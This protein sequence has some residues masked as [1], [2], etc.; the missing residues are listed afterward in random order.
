[1]P[2]GFHIDRRPPILEIT[3]DRG[4]ANVLDAATSRELGEVFLGFRDD[5]ANRVAIVTG[6]GERFFCAGWDLNAAAG[7]E[8][9]DDDFGT[10]GFGGFQSLADLNKP[11]ICAVNGMAVG[12]GFEMLLAA[13]L[14]V[15][16]E[17]A[18]FFMPEPLVGV[19]PDTGT[20]RLSRMIPDL[21]AREMLLTGKRLNA[22]EAA[23]WGLVN[24]VVPREELMDTAR[25]MANRIVEAAPLAIA[26]ILDLLRRTEGLPVPAAFE[27]MQH[28]ESY[29]RMVDSEDAVEGTTAFTEKRAPVWKGR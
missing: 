1:M 7:G 15:A 17:D 24:R 25:E 18:I 3:I 16:V 22:A 2:S 6:A 20:V 11:V 26:A 27:T 12:G 14:V 21:I 28:A 9:F 19:I 29:L 8:R 10:G 13:D 5:P 4:K 23:Q